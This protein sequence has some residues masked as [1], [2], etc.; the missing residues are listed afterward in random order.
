VSQSSDGEADVTLTTTRA[1]LT[2]FLT[3]PPPRWD[4]ARATV[5]LAGSRRAVR[6]FLK[7][8]EVFPLRRDVEVTAEC[9]GDVR[10]R[11]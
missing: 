11:Y 10:L 5:E 3:T 7:A 8:I 6:T 2:A 1:G 4:P 9:C